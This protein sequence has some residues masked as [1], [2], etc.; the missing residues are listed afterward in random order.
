[1]SDFLVEE[2]DAGAR[3]DTFAAVALDISRSNVQRHIEAGNIRVNSTQVPKRYAVKAGD[4]ITCIIP[5]PEIYRAEPQNIPIDV[6]YEDNDIIVIN[7]PQ[8]MVVHPAPGHFSGTLVNALLYHC[9]DLSGINGVLRPG[10][11]H[12]L[13]KDTSGLIVVAKNDL[14]HHGLAAQL[15]D[16]TMG[17]IY[18]AVTHGVIK[19]DKMTIDANIGR[20]PH[21][22]KRKQMAV[23]KQKPDEQK[24]DKQKSEKQGR[25]AITHIVVLERFASYTLVEARLETGR[26][27][28]IRVHLAHIGH[29][30]VGDL[31]YGPKSKCDKVA[32]TMATGQLLHAKS[33]RFVH[34]VTGEDMRFDSPLPDYIEQL[35][36]ATNRL[37]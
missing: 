31:V 8:N 18:N 26:T 14:A 10:I 21:P 29:P 4:I 11:V 2:K 25:R 37:T 6:V 12:R 36:S 27:H 15:A 33:L 24:P 28:Q 20:H 32:G 22:D 5:E 34:P 13:D 9:K 16:R 17:R 23:L 1:M 30:V 3:L 35:V 7:K 19:K